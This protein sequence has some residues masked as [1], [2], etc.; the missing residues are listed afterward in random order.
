[1]IYLLLRIIVGP[2]TNAYQKKLT[3]KG[4][5]SIFIVTITYLFLS[6]LMLPLIIT[7][8]FE[9]ID[10]KFWIS[11]LIAAVIDAVG[12]IFLVQSLRLTEL[13]VYGPINSFKPVV[14][15]V[16]AY[17][18]IA[19]KPSIN[20]ILGTLIIIGGSILLTYNKNTEKFVLHKGLV[21]R[22]IGIL[23]SALGAVYTKKAI[24]YANPEISLFFWALFGLPV[25]AIAMIILYRKNLSEN[26]LIVNTSKKLYLN[27]IVLFSLMQYLTMLAFNI[28]YVGYSLAVFQ[29]SSIVSVILGYK[30]FK[31]ENILIKLIS[32][33]IMIIGTIFIFI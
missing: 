1:M 31:E 4:A 25:L 22:F 12:N 9:N 30:F 13:S 8:S 17:F 7:S 5:N 11:I 3:E 23:F 24:V 33:I 16:L 15:M 19:E 32:S 28:T 21:Y 2:F 27:V 18:L 14:A 10:S 26:I 6:I 29:L 20:G